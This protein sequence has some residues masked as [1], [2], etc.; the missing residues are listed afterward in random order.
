MGTIQSCQFAL[1]SCLCNI[2]PK[3]MR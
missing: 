1:K 3:V 2:T